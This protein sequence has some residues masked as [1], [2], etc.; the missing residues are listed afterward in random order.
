MVACRR[1][2]PRRQN[3]H[4]LPFCRK[5]VLFRMQQVG[6]TSQTRRIDAPAGTDSVVILD[7]ANLK[8]RICGRGQSAIASAYTSASVTLRQPE[9]TYRSRKARSIWSVK[10]LT[11]YDAAVRAAVEMKISAGMPGT[12]LKP[13][14]SANAASSSWTWAM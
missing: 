2:V 9:P 12:S 11:R 3:G 1:S 14:R 8:S 4:R 6:R 5:P 7:L 13:C 10:G